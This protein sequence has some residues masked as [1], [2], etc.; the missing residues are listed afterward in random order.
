MK[1][2]LPKL[3]IKEGCPWCHAAIEWL[4]AK[5]FPYE[6]IEVRNNKAAFDEM[7]AL[8]GQT[9]APTMKLPD[10]RVLADFDVEQLPEFLNS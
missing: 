9:K 7:V 4:D 1:Q 8:S 5:N 6:L 2:E 10:G 3:Y